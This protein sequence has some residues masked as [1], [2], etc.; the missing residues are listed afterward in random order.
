VQFL[1]SSSA[2]SFRAYGAYQLGI[3]FCMLDDSAAAMG[4]FQKV[5]GWTRNGY[6]FDVY[7]A[8]KSRQFLDAGTLSEQDKLLIMAEL[9]IEAQQFERALAEP[10]AAI[11]C[12]TD[13]HR[14]VFAYCCMRCYRHLD[15]A[16]R[17]KTSYQQCIQFCASGHA[18]TYVLPHA[19]VEM[20]ELSLCMFDDRELATAYLAKANAVPGGSYDFEKPLSRRIGALTMRLSAEVS[21]PR[22]PVARDALLRSHLESFVDDDDDDGEEWARYAFQRMFRAHAETFTLFQGGGALGRR[23]G[24]GGGRYNACR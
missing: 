7:A 10:L 1:E 21:S 15:D 6:S 16:S 12:L 18:E 22:H 20:A 19:H 8:R 17:V 23:S 11:D 4:W 5:K 2:P 14:S 9:L 24:A 3:A 13:A